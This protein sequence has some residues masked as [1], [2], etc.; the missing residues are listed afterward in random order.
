MK[1]VLAPRFVDRPRAWVRRLEAWAGPATGRR[2]RV[3]RAAAI[4][5]V[6]TL[7]ALLGFRFRWVTD[8]AFIDFRIVQHV[9]AGHGPVFNLGERVEA[10]TNPLW[11]AILAILA[12]P[13]RPFLG[14][15][16]PLAW[17]AVL[18]GLASAVTG[19][20]LAQRGALRL[21]RAQGRVGSPLPL[22]ALAIVA[23]PPVWSFATSGLETGLGMG[24][25]GLC[26]WGATRFPRAGRRW[27]PFV[28]GLGPLIRPDLAIHSAGFLLILLAA[29]RPR[30]WKLLA[31]ARV[32]AAVAV[33][34]VGYQIFRMGY[35]AAIVPNTALAKEASLSRWDQGFLYLKDF[36]RPYHL[37]LP[38][39]AVVLAGAITALAPRL[40]RR[41][42]L[43]A[44][45]LVPVVC[46]L[47]QAAYVTRVGGDFMHGRMLLPAWFAMLMPSAMVAG[48]RARRPILRA[49]AVVPW[50]LLCMIALRVP[51]I[52]GPQK[53]GIGPDGI[54]DERYYY[55][56]RLGLR[57]PVTVNDYKGY[58]WAADGAEL[59]RLAEKKR[60]VVVPKP[61]KDE[62]KTRELE[63]APGV[64]SDL[65]TA[66]G[67]VGILGYAAGLRVH[68]VDRLGLGDPLAA[69]VALPQRGRPG[70]EK[71]LDDAW[72]I[73]RFAKEGE[74]G[75]ALRKA[76]KTRA[77]V[78]AA[79][80][81]LRCGE[82]GELVEAVTAPLT[83]ERFVKNVKSAVRLTKLRFPGDPAAAKAQ[84]CK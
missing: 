35:F 29:L 4:G 17:M 11:V 83:A 43:L 78:E 75:V 45:A 59:R 70:H 66:R 72:V 63:L 77:K 67:Y 53:D 33:L 82:L 19:V 24:W 2:A 56:A 74:P 47:I 40:R 30:S 5:L 41:R 8:D 52:G 44:L 14:E 9:L 54:A 23:L 48:T 20:F 34:P 12:A 3:L 32:L 62:N 84:L 28:V 81:A 36:V 65:V 64:A 15:D 73:A 13:L 16:V 31:Y 6:P 38:F 46:G 27:L 55:T 18:L 79:R 58:G 26:F 68:L 22:G 80:A 1:D 21:A 76:P 71:W 49:A 25:L 69:R 51:Y 57:N 50:A 42:R 10:Y 61:G 60:V 37:W 39:L 7:L